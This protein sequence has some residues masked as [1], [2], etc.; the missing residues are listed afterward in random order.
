[1]IGK[2]EIIENL[3]KLHILT[4]HSVLG[5]IFLLV[6]LLSSV[7]IIPI[8]TATTGFHLL[9]NLGLNY[10]HVVWRRTVDFGQAVST[11]TDYWLTYLFIRYHFRFLCLC[12]P[13]FAFQW[14]RVYYFFVLN[15]QDLFR[16][17]NIQY[18]VET[19]LTPASYHNLEPQCIHFYDY[20]LYLLFVFWGI[21]NSVA[22][23][24]CGRGTACYARK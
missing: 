23:G 22:I 24:W 14:Q 4:C 5:F 21:S 12:E 11:H 13:L 16:K 18:Q 2:K 19:T 10:G 7:H 6:A 3:R 20:F 15:D 8:C 1:M 17:V 9:F